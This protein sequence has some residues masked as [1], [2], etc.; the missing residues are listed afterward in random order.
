MVCP[1]MTL[2]WLLCPSLAGCIFETLE[3]TTCEATATAVSDDEVTPEGTAASVLRAVTGSGIAE[4]TMLDDVVGVAWAVGRGEG[5]ATWIESS[6]TTVSVQTGGSGWAYFLGGTEASCFNR[7]VVPV[8]AWI[9]TEDGSV[10]VAISTFVTSVDGLGVIPR[11]DGMGSY[12]R[13][14]F[15]PVPGVD[16]RD[17][18]DKQSVLALY[19]FDTTVSGFAGWVGSPTMLSTD[20][21]S[22]WSSRTLVTFPVP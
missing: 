19:G 21:T 17:F 11:I 15:P 22:T 4:G 14:T 9:L 20:T 10:E 5:P 7:L 1:G 3:V 16:P 8:D 13:A 12:E 18:D 6:L 2:R